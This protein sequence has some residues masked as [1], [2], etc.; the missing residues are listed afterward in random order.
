MAFLSAVKTAEEISTVGNTVTN[1]FVQYVMSDDSTSETRTVSYNFTP[2]ELAQ[3][4]AAG[5]QNARRVMARTLIKPHVKQAYL[6]WVADMASRP[7]VMTT[8]LTT[9]TDPPLTP[10]DVS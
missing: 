1:I 8:D 10:A 7:V 9:V 2:A 5:G 6:E 3:I 4:L